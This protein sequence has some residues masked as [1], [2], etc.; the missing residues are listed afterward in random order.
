MQK[1]EC[2]ACYDIG[3]LEV[4]ISS[5]GNTETQWCQ[6][7]WTIFPNIKPPSLEHLYI[8]LTKQVDEFNQAPK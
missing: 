4:T 5:N 3:Y 2:D 6:N 8:Q 7:C 1:P